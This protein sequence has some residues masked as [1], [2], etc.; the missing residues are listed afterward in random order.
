VRTIEARR[1]AYKR[2]GEGLIDADGR[3]SKI[4]SMSSIASLSI[5]RIQLSV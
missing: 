2:Q 3:V 4:W 1:I 5:G